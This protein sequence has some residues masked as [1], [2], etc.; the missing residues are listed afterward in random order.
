MGLKLALIMM[1][2][3]AAMGGL[4]YWYYTDTQERMA[5]LVAN[6][7]KATVAV[8]EA[9]AAKVAM[10]QA[11]TEMAKQNKILNEK[12]QEAENRANRL[13][14]KLSRHD[15]GVLGIAKDSL[16]E[17]IINNA[18]KNALR[19]AEIVS[20]ADL[21]QD[22]LSASKPSQ[23]NVECYEMANPNFDPTLFPTWLEKNR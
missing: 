21:T 16:V 17:K 3:M 2:L 20:G 19:C 9:E 6:E 4:G 22:E 23:I 15:I 18:S 1:V 10:E 5:I 12:F 14:N 11:Y 8:Q 7:A 13:E